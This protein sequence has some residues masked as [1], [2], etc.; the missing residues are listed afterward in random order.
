MPLKLKFDEDKKVVVKDDKPVYVDDDGKD[1]EVDVPRLFT[2]V[3][4]LNA[5]N[6][7]H[8]EEND[9]LKTTMKIFD[10]IDDLEVWK[11]EADTAAET[12]KN[13]SQKDLVEAKK[14]EEIKSAMATAHEDEKTQLLTGFQQ[15]EEHLNSQLT[16]KDA[17]IYKLMVS[18]RFSRSPFFAGAE[19]TTLLP[20]EIAETYFGKYF[21]VET[22]K[23]TKDLRVVGY[24]GVD[25]IYSRKDPGELADFDEA[26]EAVIDV[27][28]LKDR[29][30]RATGAG[31]GAGG[32]GGGGG[33]GEDETN[34]TKLEKQHA[35]AL[36]AGNVKLA[37]SL[38]NQIFKLKQDLAA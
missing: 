26:L 1:V 6:K 2:K 22:D 23:K 24:L 28:P 16:A 36:T 7:T 20:P 25:P 18:E 15:K 34:V 10:G 5:E 30:M 38:K 35:E 17:S 8:R 4:E 11:K 37:I 21:K 3:T 13:F 27:Y 19:A 32:G 12:V 31:S 33:G 29:I 9:T 14:V